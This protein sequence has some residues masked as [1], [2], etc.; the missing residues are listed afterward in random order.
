MKPLHRIHDRTVF[1]ITLDDASE[2]RF[3]SIENGLF[4]GIRDKVEVTERGNV[5]VMV[6][7]TREMTAV[8]RRA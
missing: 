3:A 7:T 6:N 5:A 8:L 1:T 4:W 2:W